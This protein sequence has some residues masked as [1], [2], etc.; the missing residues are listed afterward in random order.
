MVF[1]LNNSDVQ[2][3]NRKIENRIGVVFK[4]YEAANEFV[5]LFNEN[6]QYNVFISYNKVSCKGIINMLMLTLMIKN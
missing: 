5:D 1:H 2:K 3:I 4:N 6:N